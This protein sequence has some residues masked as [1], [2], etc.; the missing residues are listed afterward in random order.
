VRLSRVNIFAGSML[1]YWPVA[2]SITMSA[3][4]SNIPVRDYGVMMAHGLFG[5]ALLHSIHIT[6]LGAACV[7]NDILDRD[8]DRKVERT[9]NRPIASGQVSVPGALVFLGIH[10]I[11]LS[12]CIWPFNKLAWCF[13]LVAMLPL[14]GIYPL[15]KRVTYWPQAWLGIAVNFPALVAST[16]ITPRWDSAFPAAILVVSCWFWSIYYDTVYGSQDKKDDVNAGVKSTALLFGNRTRLM[17]YCFATM[18][19]GCLI[20][21]GLMNKQGPW[22]FIVGAGG[23]AAHILYQ[24][25]WV[26]PDDPQSCLYC[27]ESNAWQLGG[28]VWTGFFLDYIT[29]M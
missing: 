10:L 3:Y 19:L 14:P 26:N 8:I 1:V 5:S 7:W 15:L 21:S 16:A 2:W 24:L 6:H 20:T 17:L 12:A 23:A 9:K 27:F 13:G 29:T 22:F 4:A 11:L 28:I 25:L 18:M